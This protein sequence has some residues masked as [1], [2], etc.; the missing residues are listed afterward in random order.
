M[1]WLGQRITQTAVDAATTVKL[2]TSLGQIDQR[3]IWEIIG[4]EAVWVS[5]GVIP[6]TAFVGELNLLL[7]AVDVVTNFYSQEEIARINFAWNSKSGGA[8]PTNGRNA[9]NVNIIREKELF[10]PFQFANSEIVVSLQST[11]TGVANTMDF[12]I[13]YEEKKVTE[14][15]FLK[16]Q[17]GYCSC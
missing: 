7:K 2:A 13:Y 1:K 11:N 3:T 5:F 4:I 16:V 17:A 10:M 12:R 8:T 9:E 14:L 15:E 6:A